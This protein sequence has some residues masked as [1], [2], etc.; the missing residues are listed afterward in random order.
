MDRCGLISNKD[1]DDEDDNSN[2]PGSIAIN[3][4]KNNH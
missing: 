4:D 3:F 2:S 1:D